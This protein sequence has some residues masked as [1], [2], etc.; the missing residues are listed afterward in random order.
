MEEDGASLLTPADTGLSVF[1][2]PRLLLRLCQDWLYVLL[3]TH[4]EPTHPDYISTLYRPLL[5]IVQID[6]LNNK[7][8]SYLIYQ[9]HLHPRSS[10]ASYQVDVTQVM[11][12]K[13][14]QG[15]GDSVQLIGFKGLLTL[16]HCAVE[17]GAD[18]PLH[19]ACRNRLEREE[20]K[21]QSEGARGAQNKLCMCGSS[22]SW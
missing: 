21:E 18:P 5:Y 15:G 9:G 14:V 6:I 3:I 16:Q 13:G 8:I 11:N 22:R 12:P 7:G 1:L 2:D 4:R 19:T 17:S 20:D 10:H